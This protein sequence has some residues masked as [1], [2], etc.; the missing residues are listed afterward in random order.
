MPAAEPVRPVP[1]AA[2]LGAVDRSTVM[3]PAESLTEVS[4]IRRRCLDIILLSE[5]DRTTDR[6]FN[7]NHLLQVHSS[8]AATIHH[9]ILRPSGDDPDWDPIPVAPQTSQLTDDSRAD[10]FSER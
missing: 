8:E 2:D 7:F 4:A 3:P 9:S 6:D 10:N 1:D 5:T